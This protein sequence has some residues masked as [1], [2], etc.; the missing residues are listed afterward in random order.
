LQRAVARLSGL[1]SET[2]K[3]TDRPGLLEGA[4]FA[5]RAHEGKRQ[6]R[7]DSSNLA[8]EGALGKDILAEALRSAVTIRY[9]LT[10]CFKLLKKRSDHL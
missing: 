2:E 3:S 1:G 6:D 4:W 5:D 7:S 9:V 10:Q 8:E